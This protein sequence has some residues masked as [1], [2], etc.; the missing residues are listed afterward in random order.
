M[1]CCWM[2]VGD[3]KFSSASN[4]SMLGFEKSKQAQCLELYDGHKAGH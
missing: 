2:R 1:A 4:N 3:M